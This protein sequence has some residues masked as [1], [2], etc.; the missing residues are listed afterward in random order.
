MAICPTGWSSTFHT[1]CE[2]CQLLPVQAKQCISVHYCTDLPTSAQSGWPS[3]PLAGWPSVPLEN[4]QS[5]TQSANVGSYSPPRQTNSSGN[6]ICV[7]DDE[8][9]VPGVERVCSTVGDYFNAIQQP[10]VESDQKCTW[11]S[12]FHTVCECCQLPPVQA[13]QYIS[14]H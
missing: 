14:A 10:S 8:P 3:A 12:I 11:S 2:C 4:Y 13:K 6:D 7:V 5:P 9:Y 1:V